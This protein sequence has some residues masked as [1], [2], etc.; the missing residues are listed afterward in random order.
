MPNG[1][2]L[3]LALAT[4][5]KFTNMPCAVSGRRY[6]TEPESSTG[7]AWVLNM[8]LNWRASVSSPR[9]PQ[10]G[11][12]WGAASLSWRGRAPQWRPAAHGA[13]EGAGGAPAPPKGGG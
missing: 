7:P 3:R 8:R 2:R 4:F 11:H 6:A 10:V 13:G 1:G 9:G 5:V 12:T